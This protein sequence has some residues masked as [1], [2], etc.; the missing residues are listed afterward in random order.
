M[1]LTLRGFKSFASATTFEFTPGINAVVGPNGSG[2]S[3][4][5]D[6]LAWVMG[7]QGAKSLRGGSMKDVIFAGSGE[8]GSGDGAQRAPLGRAKVTLTFD[9]SDGTLSIPADR[10][11]ISRTMFRSGGSE[12]EI[13]GSPARLADIQD[14][15]S[16][17]GL[18]QQ[19]HVLVGQGQLD[20]VLH[21]TAQQRRDMIEQAAGVVKYRRRQEKTS[22]KLESVASNVTRLS[23]LVAEL[24]SQLQPLSEQAESA[25]TARQLQ[26]RI[27]QLEAVLLA[28]QLGVLQAEQAQALASE[29]EGTRRAETL[30]EQLEAA[31]AASAKHQQ[32]QNRLN[33]EVTACQKAVSTLRESA[34]RVRT[35]Q[36]IA[37]ERVRTYR[38]EL[39]EATAAAR[40]G[41]ERALELLEERREEAERAVESYASFEERYDAALKN[42]EKAASEVAQTERAS[43]EAAQSRARAQAQLD[44]AR[45]AAVEA[46]RAYAAAAERAATLREALGQSLG[47][48]SAEL[49]T[50]SAEA[51]FDPETGELMDSSSEGASLLRV[52]DAVQIDPEYARAA[53]AA[54]TSLA[55]AA[56]SVPVEGAEV[57][58]LRGDKDSDKG[59]ESSESAAKEL[60]TEL[61]ETTL[62]ESCAAEL[63]ELGIR[64]ATEII[65]PLS[66]DAAALAGIDEH[67][68]ARV[69]A[70][71]GERLAGV[72]FAPDAASAEHALQLLAENT[73][74]GQRTMW[75]IFD[76]AGTEHTRYS[77]LYPAEGA[78]PLELAAAYRAASQV[79]TRTRA[80][81]DEAE[82]A[83]QQAQTAAEAAVEAEREAAKAAGVASAEH[84]RA[85]A[86]AESLEASA[87]NIQ[88]ERARLNERLT[89]A[90]ES[91]AQ[92]RVA[93]E[94]ARTREDS[95]LAGTGEQAPA[96]KIERRAQRLGEVLAEQVSE[97]EQQLHE[98]STALKNAQE[99]LTSTNDEVQDLQAAHAAALT[100]LARTQTEAARVQERVQALAERA[101]LVTGL[102]L[103]QLEEEYPE[104][105]PV[106]V[107]AEE[108][109][110]NAASENV[111]SEN[112]APET[113]PQP[114]SETTEA[115][116][117]SVRARLK[118]TRAELEALGAINP[119]ALEE[120]EALSE[121]HAYLN[122]QI[123]DL[124]ATRRDLNTV[125]D[126]VSSH[127]AEVF[128]AAMEDINTHYR[129]IFE[130]LFP[131]GEGHLELD[132]PSDPLNSGVEIHARPAGKKVKRLSL[133]SG[134]ER[135]LASLALLIAIYMSRPSP[136]YALDEVEAA[137]DDR[138]LSRLLQVIGELGERSQLIVVT[139]QKR[140]MQIAETLYGVSMRGG[141]STVLSQQ[142]EELRELL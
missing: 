99:G 81:L 32:E 100:L 46:T 62:P 142:M 23:D 92:A 26:A 30:K 59:D 104:Q 42:V 14:L 9:N 77:L 95:Y 97:R 94:S 3:N 107:P 136:F 61:P 34:A 47:E 118:A 51:V 40:A 45:A 141:V 69:T 121:R 35:V 137:L 93:Y 87:Q 124:K 67:A 41:Y 64:P 119:L 17:A 63:R 84:A 58:Q 54:L 31:R 111:A 91:V 49:D 52:L 90:E 89:A 33:A 103:E 5:L 27:R 10:V 126:E 110:E 83:V 82:H 21:A 50:E 134:G 4:V 74:A 48:A 16:E 127:I 138:N 20:A 7:E 85:R 129:R 112:S 6:A 36:S 66:E 125:M 106:D 131:G 2:K 117:E 98:L 38:V 133:L 65:E 78:S 123:E 79:V 132:D 56:L 120:Y 101:R 128:T 15:L 96:A 115:S 105:L 24:D 135:S 76:P 12:Y 75:R 22:R 1:S 109:P 73:L 57:S 8:A 28:R 44:A 102:T 70:A 53:S 88:A 71:L 113:A 37:A 80:E 55:T 114:A 13:N 122:Q 18:G 130:T 116:T 60:S 140:T 39:T 29:A 86:Q 25:A 19:M 139:H 108:A 43:G 68:L 11:Q 72:L